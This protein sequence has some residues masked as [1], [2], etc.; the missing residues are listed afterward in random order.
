MALTCIHAGRLCN[1]CG[2]C[3]PDARSPRC[4][5]CRRPIAGG[6]Y[7]YDIDTRV[8]CTDCLDSYVKEA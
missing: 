2:D 1:G 7:Y 3:R 4:D 5:R 6:E 8:L